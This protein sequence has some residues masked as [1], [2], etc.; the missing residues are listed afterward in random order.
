MVKKEIT[1]SIRKPNKQCF[2]NTKKMF[3]IKS[4]KSNLITKVIMFTCP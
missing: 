3:Y 4:M 1:Y 2:P